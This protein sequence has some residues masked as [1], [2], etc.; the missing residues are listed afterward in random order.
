MTLSS[1]P[2]PLPLPQDHITHLKKTARARTAD[3]CEEIRAEA[4]C[5]LHVPLHLS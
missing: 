1:P 4:C 3:T 5:S 2:F